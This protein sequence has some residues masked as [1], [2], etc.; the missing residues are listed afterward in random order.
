[1]D[2]TLKDIFSASSHE[3]ISE[4][5]YTL[6]AMGEYYKVEIAEGRLTR[7]EA[8]AKWRLL[9]NVRNMISKVNL[10]VLTL[11]PE[12]QPKGESKENQKRIQKPKKHEVSA[13]SGRLFG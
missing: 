12:D 3:I 8:A 1:M 6:K 10:E 9:K 4:M 11:S 13:P 5:D 2:I 7:D